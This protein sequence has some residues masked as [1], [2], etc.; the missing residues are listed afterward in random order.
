MD[1]KDILLHT[2]AALVGTLMLSWLGVPW[3]VI[4]VTN[5]LFWP[6]REARQHWPDPDEVFTHPQSLLEW[7]APVLTGFIIYWILT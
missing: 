7:L 6:L 5:T 3:N 2:I 4:L 1:W